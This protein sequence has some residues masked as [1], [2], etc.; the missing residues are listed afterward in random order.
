MHRQSLFPAVQA[1]P[2]NAWTPRGQH[3]GQSPPPPATPTD[4]HRT[5][6][7]P[8]IRSRRA[9]HGRMRH[10]AALTPTAVR[11]GLP[12][13]GSGQPG[14]PPSCCACRAMPARAGQAAQA[15]LQL[16]LDSPHPWRQRLRRRRRRRRRASIRGLHLWRTP[17]PRA[18]SAG[19]AARRRSKIGRGT[20][21][22]AS[23][24]AAHQRRV[25]STPCSIGLASAPVQLP[26]IRVLT[27]AAPHRPEH[28][29]R[30]RVASPPPGSSG[31]GPGSGTSGTSE[32]TA[33]D[34]CSPAACRCRGRCPRGTASSASE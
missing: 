13:A 15:A 34:R 8:R 27:S 31:L 17:R 26:S 10:P 30:A 2:G 19:P 16:F 25:G 21:C 11:R 7:L 24:A 20:C 33:T 6:P 3:T 18:P 29:R 1:V 9:D 22:Y 23:R 28:P 32:T 5:G 4:Q 14:W 12:K